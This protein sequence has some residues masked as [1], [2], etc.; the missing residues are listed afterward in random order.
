MVLRHIA[1][2]VAA[3]SL[4]DQSSWEPIDSQ[5]GRPHELGRPTG[6]CRVGKASLRTHLLTVASACLD[7]AGK[8][9]RR[10]GKLIR[11]HLVS[12]QGHAPVMTSVMASSSRAIA[13]G[14]VLGPHARRPGG[15]QAAAHHRDELL[16]VLD[17]L[18]EKNPGYAPLIDS[19]NLGNWPKSDLNASG[20]TRM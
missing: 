17:R 12:V 16:L 11:Q 13:A 14:A 19:G 10:L 7:C 5:P 3:N 4:G 15:R 6:L 2:H 18:I 20:V 8:V 1:G 9:G